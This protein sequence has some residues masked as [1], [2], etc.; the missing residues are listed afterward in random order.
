MTGKSAYIERTTEVSSASAVR[1]LIPMN[2]SELI[3][4]LAGRF[5]QLSLKD[6]NCTVK[7]LLGAISNALAQG[8]RVEIRGFGSFSLKHYPARTG[9][10]P[11]TGEKVQIPEKYAPHFKAGK[12]LRERVKRC[13][14]RLPD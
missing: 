10:N 5:S 2:Q 3:T 1:F 6:A 4:L 7:I 12:E 11:K 13:L 14:E 9:R 8:R